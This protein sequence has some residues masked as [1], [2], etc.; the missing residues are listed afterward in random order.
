M[1]RRN[2]YITWP[3]RICRLLGGACLSL[4]ILLPSLPTLLQFS[5]L[6]S[7]VSF[8]LFLLLSYYRFYHHLAVF[9]FW[10][11]LLCKTYSLM[12]LHRSKIHL[13]FLSYFNYSSHNLFFFFV[14]VITVSLFLWI[15]TI[16]LL[17]FFLFRCFFTLHSLVV[18]LSF[19]S[20]SFFLP[21]LCSFPWFPHN[22]SSLSSF[23]S[24]STAPL[25]HSLTT[26]ASSLLS[27]S[28]ILFSLP[29]SPFLFPF[30]AAQVNEC[31]VWGD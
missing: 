10:Y 6:A 8:S 12:T 28:V 30:W 21:S 11:L 20:F 26:T 17:F 4:S 27:L 13:T 18:C 31:S 16:F 22:K 5:L 2:R 15:V 19:S 14:F 3:T 25:T 7:P 1:R 29:S 23:Q 9:P 24:S